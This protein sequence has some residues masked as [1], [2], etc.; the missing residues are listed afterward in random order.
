MEEIFLVHTTKLTG[1]E[2]FFSEY[3]Y[4]KIDSFVFLSS[5]LS[6]SQVKSQVF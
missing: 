5:S 3:V 1:T 2:A 6:S 4:K